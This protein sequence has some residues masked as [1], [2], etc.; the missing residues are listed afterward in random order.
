MDVRT[1]IKPHRHLNHYGSR[2]PLYHYVLSV[3][4][5]P[6]L[7]STVMKRSNERT[8]NLKLLM[9]TLIRFYSF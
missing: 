3:S 6:V 1:T 8:K 5:T 9:Q 7:T 4:Q 2:R